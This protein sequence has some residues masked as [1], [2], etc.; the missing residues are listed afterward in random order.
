M[1]GERRRIARLRRAD[2]HEQRGAQAAHQLRG[3]DVGSDIAAADPL[4]QMIE[5]EFVGHEDLV[6]A[7]EALGMSV[8]SPMPG[9]AP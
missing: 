9:T 2:L 3:D 7:R 6:R 5:I 8:W 4:A 1:R